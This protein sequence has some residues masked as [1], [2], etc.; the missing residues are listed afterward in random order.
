MISSTKNN[1]R[2]SL[3]VTR[4]LFKQFA[5]PLSCICLPVRSFA[6]HDILFS[7]L[8]QELKK[9]IKHWYQINKDTLITNKILY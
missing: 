8:M 1:I 2:H 4:V 5:P 9:D 3:F 6:V 7:Y